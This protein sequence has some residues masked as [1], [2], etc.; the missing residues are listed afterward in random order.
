MDIRSIVH[1]GK[2]G[3]TYNKMKTHKSINIKS[4]Y[5]QGTETVIKYLKSGPIPSLYYNFSS[6]G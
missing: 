2:R 4:E 1:C 6:R 3:I 5:F